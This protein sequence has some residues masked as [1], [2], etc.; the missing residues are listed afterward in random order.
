MNLKT[1]TIGASVAA[2]LVGGIFLSRTLT[3]AEPGYVGVVTQFGSVEAKPLYAGDGPTIISP[4]KSVVMLPTMQLSH[5]IKVAAATIKGQTAPTEIAIAYSVKGEMWPLVYKTIGGKAAIDANYFDNN[6]QQALK[7]I[8]GNYLALRFR[9]STVDT[10]WGESIFVLGELPEL[11]N[12]RPFEGNKMGNFRP[13]DWELKLK[14]SSFSLLNKVSRGHEGHR[15]Q[16]RQ[17]QRD[18]AGQVGGRR[19]GAGLEPEDRRE[20]ADPLRESLLRELLE[21]AQSPHPPA[22]RGRRK[23]RDIL[24]DRHRRRP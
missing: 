18:S 1:I 22:G 19:V 16:V 9:I 14:I 23:H 7:Q 12:W 5:H 20:R 11:G 6:A 2:L 21:Q 13:D 24:D 4:L 8:T 17:V 3:W 10:A 15:V